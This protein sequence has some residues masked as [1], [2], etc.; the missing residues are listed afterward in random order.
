[1]WKK[2]N[3][4]NK[5]HLCI[6][7]SC[8]HF[9]CKLLIVTSVISAGCVVPVGFKRLFFCVLRTHQ[10]CSKLQFCEYKTSKY[11]YSHA[12][13]GWGGAIRGVIASHPPSFVPWLLPLCPFLLLLS[14]PTPSLGRGD[15]RSPVWRC[16]SPR[17]VLQS[18]AKGRVWNS[19]T[20]F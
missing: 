20:C 6:V 18:Y 14:P 9:L 16:F 4:M 12:V 10:F 17:T 11:A 3:Y 1:M 19:F 2:N 7:N 15:Q 5:V 13:T 8:E